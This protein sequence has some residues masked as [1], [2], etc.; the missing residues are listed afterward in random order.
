MSKG[1]HIKGIFGRETPLTPPPRPSP[2]SQSEGAKEARQWHISQGG[3]GLRLA[4]HALRLL[5][6]AV[7]LAVTAG[8]SQEEIALA[9]A[10][11]ID[12][13]RERREFTKP[14]D[15]L[16]KGAILE[17]LADVAIAVD[18]LEMHLGRSLDEE[19]LAK[20]RVLYQ[21]E[22]LVDDDGVLYRPGRRWPIRSWWRRLFN[23]RGSA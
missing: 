4:G 9:I 3:R 12:K 7:E 20:V 13:A 10:S 18:I 6:E 2:L 16:P 1:D 22:W 5:V 8:A 17:E 19:K 21:R 15:H 14:G 23:V 11:E